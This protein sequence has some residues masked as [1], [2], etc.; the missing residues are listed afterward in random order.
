MNGT[1]R[2]LCC[3]AVL[4][5]LCV[6]ARAQTTEHPWLQWQS[7]TVCD[8]DLSGAYVGRHSG[9]VLAAGGVDGQGRLSDRIFALLPQADGA[10]RWIEAGR[11]PRAMAQ[12]ASAS[13]AEG[14][15]CLGGNNEQGPCAD[16]LLL[17]WDA[18]DKQVR[19]SEQ[20]SLPMALQ[21]AAA[22]GYG[23]AIYV[24]GGIGADGALND[25][26]L[27]LEVQQEAAANWTELPKLPS[28]PI[29]AAQFLPQG[30]AENNWLY[31][32]G[33]HTTE[34]DSA[35]VW[36]YQPYRRQWQAV[37]PMPAAT[38][39]AA[40]F[41]LGAAHIL[42]VSRDDAVYAYHTI[43]DTWITAPVD[44]P[45]L[46]R[47]Y[48][49]AQNGKQ[50][51]LVGANDG[52]LI[53][54]PG[55]A[56]FKSSQLSLADY[57]AL[58]GYLLF[59]VLVGLYFTNRGKSTKDYFLGGNRIPW[60]AAGLSLLATQVSSIGFMA[61]PA[62]TFATD[63][64]YFLG[65][66]TWFMVVPIVIRFYIPFFRKLELT[67]AYEYL[68]LRFNLP[69]RLLSALLFCL[70]QIGRLSVV[71]YLPALALAAVTGI[72]QTLCILM[73]GLLAT[74]Y[75][76][77]GGMEAVVWTDVVQT[78]LLLAGVLLSIAFV[79]IKIGGDVSQF[80]HI[81][82]HDHKMQLVLPGHDASKAVLWVVILGY[83]F[84]RFAGLSSDQANVQRYLTTRDARQAGRA[85]WL[86][87]AVSIPWAF[88]VFFLGTALYVFYK[89]HPSWLH[90]AVDTNGIVPL[91][92]AQAFPPGLAGVIIA[93]IFAAAM[94]SL[95]SSMHSTST[96][97]VTDFY[98]RLLPRSNDR[99]RLILA[100]AMVG[101]LGVFGTITA[102]Y[103]ASS[104]IKS[105]WDQFGTILGLFVGAVAGLFVLGLF[106]V[107]VDGWDALIGGIVGVLATTYVSFYTH[108]FFLLYPAVGVLVTV[109][110]AYAASFIPRSRRLARQLTVFAP[111]AAVD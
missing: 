62:K 100:K 88:T 64:A 75:T 8:V 105:V 36:R 97:L 72:D 5:S 22:A 34:G 10:T 90:P 31:L 38:A 55:R 2:V 45:D 50:V 92:V 95:D 6:A 51:T 13:T 98:A 48:G 21:Q 107:R 19:V 74:I 25:R 29:A 89:L 84:S 12:G 103:L 66:L 30:G 47:L 1:L 86:D 41:A 94:S 69:V 65:I 83:F 79:I 63:W 76:Y 27:S 24:V 61:V 3:L 16:V 111:Q 96:V 80:T 71:L 14:V 91:F 26:L 78:G 39:Q 4:L 7:P 17:Q 59:I 99:A 73:T 81:V 35:L 42:V 23:S 49:V 109:I 33:G 52:Q 20:T 46:K 56:T 85:L 11:L 104:Q 28:G 82:L 58:G 40:A 57:L 60:W 37:T 70:L 102:L 15:W 18:A 67:S 68:E 32:I 53:A 54:L 87:V 110:V 106:T 43:T 93:A 9:V 44:I 77:F 108:A 101:L